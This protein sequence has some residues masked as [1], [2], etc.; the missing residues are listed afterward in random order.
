M[1]VSTTAEN[2]MQEL[3]NENIA[4]EIVYNLD[5][6]KHKISFNVKNSPF[7]I[8]H[9]NI[10]S[11]AKNFDELQIIVADS[12][13]SLDL[14]ILSETWN[15]DNLQFYHIEGYTTHYNYSKFN[16]NDGVVVFSKLPVSVKL[17]ELSEHYNIIRIETVVKN[18]I[19]GVTSVYKP[20]PYK[21]STF[22]QQL[23]QYLKQNNKM[24]FEILVGDF[25]ID[26]LNLRDQSTHEYLDVLSRYGF[27]SC[28]NKPTREK[29]CLDHIFIKTNITN[30][31]LYPA[32][33]QSKI[34]DHNPVFLQIALPDGNDAGHC[35]SEVR[36]NNKKCTNI[37]NYKKMKEK[38][39]GVDWQQVV[40]GDTETSLRT[41]INIIQNEL[42]NCS[43]VKILNNKFTKRKPWMTNGIIRS[44]H[45]RDRLYH[46][47]CL[48]PSNTLIKDTYLNYKTSISRIIQK[49]KNLYYKQ[50]IE[51][52]KNNPRKLWSL[53]NES[54]NKPTSS[55]NITSLNINGVETH[56]I[57]KIVNKFNHY[58]TNVSKTL[59]AKIKPNKMQQTCMLNKIPKNNNNFYLIPTHVN[60][61]KVIIQTLKNNK[62]TGSDGLSSE[63]LKTISSIIAQPLATIF[64]NCF[65]SGY[66][67]KCLKSA[68]VIPVF[69]SGSKEMINNYRPISLISN[70]AKIL[71]KLIKVRLISFLTNYKIL[72]NCQ[73]GF[74]QNRGTDDAISLLCSSVYDALDNSR[75]C[76]A[77]F[78]DLAKAFDTV[79]HLILIKKMEICGIRGIPL[80][81]FQSYLTERT[82]SVKIADCQSLSESITCGVPQGTVIGPLLFLIYINDLLLS[83]ELT[84]KLIAYA[85]DTVLV[86]ESESWQFTRDAAMRDMAVVKSWLDANILSLN[87][88]KTVFLS[89]SIYANGQPTFSE[90]VV[91]N[92]ECTRDHTCSCNV[93]INKVASV[94]Y[95]G[96]TMDQHMRWDLHI[97]NLCQKL[98]KTIY[99]FKK[100]RDILIKTLLY[101]FYFALVQSLLSYGVIGWGGAAGLYLERVKIIQKSII[102][103][104]LRKPLAYPSNLL[105]AETKIL[106]L[107]NL[108]YNSILRYINKMPLSI[109]VHSHTYS[110]R[111]RNEAVPIRT[112]KTIGHRCFTYYIPKIYNK[113]QQYTQVNNITLNKRNYQKICKRF[114]TDC[115]IDIL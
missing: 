49:T 44:I 85:D 42:K 96:I 3:E 102:K 18:K 46:Q 68:L 62:S 58:F 110:T 40:A 32:V 15:I 114:L 90:L 61:V 100:L 6:L 11:I 73:F 95:L 47:S 112:T 43:T 14:I 99:I 76:I 81:L 52:C 79:D 71:E 23:D 1:M 29:S 33:I 78:L 54:L 87:D 9:T 55:H 37:I 5:A 8:F 4:T 111:N 80:Q 83:R 27:N 77:V 2:L 69:K 28:I 59:A 93:I 63:T 30:N 107:P 88:S 108:F 41:L 16:Q 84:G 82:Q 39:Q 72:S 97:I 106:S 34:T 109:T 115:N 38:L 94:K 36:G 19:I 35:N 113:F 45:I 21:S 104:M 92:W 101:S 103:V 51:T 13:L 105:Y 70:I 60:E 20:P 98:R 75:S 67:P 10:R 66:F 86:V 64:N 26:I 17:V 31:Q 89:F 91:H 22:I 53:A 57:N 48:Y 74:T 50:K 24:S 65:V 25:N 56:C 12:N 7:R